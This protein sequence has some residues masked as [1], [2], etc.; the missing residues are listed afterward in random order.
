MQVK[1]YTLVT[2]TRDFLQPFCREDVQYVQQFAKDPEAPASYEFLMAAEVLMREN[3]LKIP[4]TVHEAIDFY[5][6]L[7]HLLYVEV[8]D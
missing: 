1:Y 5:L 8:M 7:K 6:E 4:L 3:N 2:G